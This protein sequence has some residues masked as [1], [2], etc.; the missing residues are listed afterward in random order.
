MT[1]KE[2]EQVSPWSSGP[3]IFTCLEVTKPDGSKERVGEWK[4]CESVENWNKPFL[5]ITS[6]KDPT[7]KRI[8][9]MNIKGIKAEI[10]EAR[11]GAKNALNVLLSEA[12]GRNYDPPANTEVVADL[13][14]II[15]TLNKVVDEFGSV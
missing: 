13:E 14:H 15:A 3:M 1:I 2:I 11:A 6:F 9:E 12:E 5:G 8:K 10:I 7:I 4:E